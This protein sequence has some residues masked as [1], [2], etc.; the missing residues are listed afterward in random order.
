MELVDARP[1]AYA[2]IRSVQIVGFRRA[3]SN[4]MIDSLLGFMSDRDERDERPEAIPRIFVQVDSQ[5][6]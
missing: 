5:Y 2:T 3:I 4:Q 1:V 6:C